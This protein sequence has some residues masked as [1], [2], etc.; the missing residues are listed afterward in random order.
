[1]THG[2]YDRREWQY[3]W[4]LFLKEENWTT[5]DTPINN[6]IRID[7]SNIYA[8]VFDELS[9]EEI[10]NLFMDSSY[11]IDDVMSNLKITKPNSK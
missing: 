4:I 3:E 9:Q 7:Y 6:I 1:M 11:N 2:N 8:D 5:I 10:D